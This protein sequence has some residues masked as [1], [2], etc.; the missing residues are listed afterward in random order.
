MS[1][2]TPRAIV[3]GLAL[4]LA[5][6]SEPPERAACVTFAE[7]LERF[8]ADAID[9]ATFA[10]EMHRVDELADG[11]DVEDEATDIVTV[12]AFGTSDEQT[13]AYLAMIDACSDHITTD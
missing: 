6:C 2:T 3:V 12:I 9:D 10:G 5:G 4:V 13:A 1:V 8:R 11:T 7:Q